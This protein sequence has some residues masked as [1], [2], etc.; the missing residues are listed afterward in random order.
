MPWPVL[1]KSQGMDDWIQ[2][3]ILALVAG[4]A[5]FGKVTKTLI[6]KFSPK[7]DPD[8]TVLG[9]PEPARRRP[10]PPA[11]P[12]ARPMPQPPMATP[13]ATGPVAPPARPRP[14][15]KFPPVESLPKML[16]EVFAQLRDAGET[17]PSRPSPPPAA[18]PPPARAMPGVERTGRKPV[19]ARKR[20]RSKPG[21]T[22]AAGVWPLVAS[23]AD[24]DVRKTQIKDSPLDT[25]R[26]P[27]RASLRRAIIM[28]EILSPP[29]ALRRVDERE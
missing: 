18:P 23:V 2:V 26:H 21:A 12:M 16:R 13:Q 17:S 19:A 29:L 8:T 4:S 20:A 6:R 3:I 22:P 5:V 27:T 25:V 15:P 10:P 14:V 28:N 9:R 7:K 1:G 24:G 11:R